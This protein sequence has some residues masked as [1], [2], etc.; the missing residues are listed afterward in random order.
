MRIIDEMWHD[1]IL[2]TYD[3]QQF[4]HHYFG[5]FIHHQVN[6]RDKLD[7]NQQTI[8]EQEFEKETESF[9]EYIYDNLGQETFIRWFHS[10]FPI[11][12]VT[13]NGAQASI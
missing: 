8:N 7:N 10:H 2:M 9:F 3:Y 6:Q 4:C 5:H 13:N 12:V 11:E 1:F